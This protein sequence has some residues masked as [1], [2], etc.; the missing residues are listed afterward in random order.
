M[1]DTW[2]SASRRAASAAWCA[3]SAAWCAASAAWRAERSA[4]RADCKSCMDGTGAEA[5]SSPL[6]ASAPVGLCGETALPVSSWPA[7]KAVGGRVVELVELTIVASPGP[8]SSELSAAA[9]SAA[10]SP[11]SIVDMRSGNDGEQQWY[12]W[13]RLGSDPRR[14]AQKQGECL[15]RSVSR[16]SAGKQRGAW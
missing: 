9:P 14:A 6:P 2:A 12:V 10:V 8:S 13:S 15:A 4:A 7:G 11:A 5:T 1:L 16:H 3:A